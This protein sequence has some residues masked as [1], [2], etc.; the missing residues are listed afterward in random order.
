L[1]QHSAGTALPAITLGTGLRPPTDVYRLVGWA[2][3]MGYRSFD[4]AALY[5]T[6]AAIGRAI[7]NSGIDRRELFITVKVRGNEYGSRARVH[8]AIE[9][10]LDA[11]GTSFADMVVPHWPLPMVRALPSTFAQM[12]DARAEGMVRGVG[13]SNAS[14][15]MVR[16]VR[17]ETGEWP[18]VNQLHLS[19]IVGQTDFT[20]FAEAVP[21][22]IQ[23]YR[24]LESGSGLMQTRFISELSQQYGCSPAQLLIG[25]QLGLG[26]RVVLGASTLEQ[27]RANL[28][29]RPLELAPADRQRLARLDRFSLAKPDPVTHFEL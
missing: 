27:L 29:S 14:S 2:L 23:A 12:L 19:P 3:D 22:G 28:D 24:V 18:V 4:T 1:S 16:A 20:R 21:V 6:E 9:R 7:R 17:T 8:Q 5:G 26:H 11:L 13:L 15:A 10:S 25:W